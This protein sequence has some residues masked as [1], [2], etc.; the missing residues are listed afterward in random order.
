MSLFLLYLHINFT[1][2]Y[3]KAS[4]VTFTW[5]GMEHDF[6]K[7]NITGVHALFNNNVLFFSYEYIRE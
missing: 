7:V 1:T 6:R 5:I 2:I 4:V 3:K